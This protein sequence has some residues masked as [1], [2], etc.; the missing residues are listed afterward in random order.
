MGW[1]DRLRGTAPNA[2]RLQAAIARSHGDRYS[3]GL[4]AGRLIAAAKTHGL[5]SHLE[6]LSC[7]G[8]V[9]WLSGPGQPVRTIC[10]R[11]RV[12]PPAGRPA[13]PSPQQ[14][15]SPTPCGGQGLGTANVGVTG[16]LLGLWLAGM[17]IF[18]THSRAHA[19]VRPAGQSPVLLSDYQSEESMTGSQPAAYRHYVLS[20]EGSGS[21]M[22]PC[23]TGRAS[24]N[25]TN[26]IAWSS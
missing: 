3:L 4:G 9:G 16:C 13:P 21:L 8:T 23:D 10:P 14:A 20:S 1:S 18:I 11:S 26:A 15:S 2:P 5:P 22:S 7:V 12:G 6:A 19:H 17:P 25:Q 24:E